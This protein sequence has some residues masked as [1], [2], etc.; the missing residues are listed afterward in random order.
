MPLGRERETE[1][2]VAH[3]RESTLEAGEGWGNI[4][5]VIK[6]VASFFLSS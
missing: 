6:V 2:G 3:R 1:T 5:R 4:G